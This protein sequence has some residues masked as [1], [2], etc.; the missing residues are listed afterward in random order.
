M[1][2][3]RLQRRGELEIGRRPNGSGNINAAG[4][5]D[6]RWNGKR[7]YEHI[8]VAERALGKALPPNALVHHV[9][10]IKSDNRPTNLVVCPDESYHRLVHTR[11]AALETC[12]RPDWR[13]C[14]ICQKY[15]DPSV[16]RGGR[17]TEHIECGREY[18]RLRYERKKA[19]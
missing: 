2:Q 15:D 18:W 8:V 1:H 9:N 14:W 13:K 10:E 11:M 4:Y 17:Q 16:M 5:V 7:T 19:A 6:V 12:G 3:M